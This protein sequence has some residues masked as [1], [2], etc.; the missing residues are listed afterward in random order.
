MSSDKSSSNHE[1]HVTS[2]FKF[3]LVLV[4]L[5]LLTTAT[6]MVASFNFGRLEVAVALAVALAKAA[7]VAWYFMH[8][9]DEPAYIRYSL[10]GVFV[11]ITLI[12]IFTFFDYSFR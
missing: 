2:Y 9:K 12:L 8:L 3:A 11:L 5:L 10:L 4:A 6:I 7:I 1:G